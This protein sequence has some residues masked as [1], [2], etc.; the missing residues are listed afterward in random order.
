VS[1]AHLHIA[2]GANRSRSGK[3]K[4]SG[5]FSDP[6]PL[7][8]AEKFIDPSTKM[9]IRCT[10]FAHRIQLGFANRKNPARICMI[11]ASTTSRLSSNR[12]YSFLEFA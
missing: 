5:L 3:V 9:R 11:I 12:E 10:P 2:I 4:R 6:A 8:V 7:K 1:F